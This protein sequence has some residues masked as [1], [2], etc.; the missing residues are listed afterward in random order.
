MPDQPIGKLTPEQSLRFVELAKRADDVL[1]DEHPMELMARDF[2]FIAYAMGVD[3][4]R[5]I[6]DAVG[7]AIALERAEPGTPEALRKAAQRVV[8]R[9]G[10]DCGILVKVIDGRTLDDDLRGLRTALGISD[11]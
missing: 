8:D 10:E 3:R 5:Y 11:E 2:D 4:A 7:A 9:M 6:R 1:L